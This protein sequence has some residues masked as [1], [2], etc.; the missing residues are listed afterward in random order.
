MKRKWLFI[1]EQP[2]EAASCAAL[3]SQ[4]GECLVETKQPAAD[5]SFI[6][7]ALDD[8][9]YTGVLLDHALNEGSAE[10]TYAGSTIAAFIRSEYPHL[11]V[12]VLSA[13][14][15]VPAESRRYRRTEDLFDLKLDKQIVARD[16]DESRRKLI[17]LDDGYQNLNTVLE[18]GGSLATAMSILGIPVDLD[19]DSQRIELA[20]LI[21]EEGG[22]LEEGGG[23]PCEVAQFLLQTAL[24]L[25]G[26]LLDRR[27][28]AVVAGLAPNQSSEV[29]AVLKDAK[30]HGVFAELHQE[31]R[32]WR[33]LLSELDEPP[34]ALPRAKCVVCDGLASEVCERCLRPV[35]G[36]HSLPVRR[37]VVANDMFLRGRMCAFC[38]GGDLPEELVIEGSYAQMVPSLV[39]QAEKIQMER[40]K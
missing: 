1:D 38:L 20:H 21:L 9:M 32:Y 4:D 6:R 2:E 22:L 29:D 3:L 40:N 26:P 39:D 13:R 34:K 24:R 5:L 12:V 27:R 11:P 15:A 23:D 31:G 17:A 35:D 14:L 36:L 28:A 7:E 16:P 25:Q 19:D 18:D 8:G 37:I 33:E 30:Y 10:I